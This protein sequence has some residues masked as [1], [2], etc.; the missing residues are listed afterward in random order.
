[1]RLKR[2]R[3]WAARPSG[4]VRRVV[5]QSTS[6]ELVGEFSILIYLHPIH[7]HFDGC[8]DLWH[9]MRLGR[10]ARKLRQI[11]NGSTA[12]LRRGRHRDQSIDH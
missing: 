3:A 6:A 2:V 1:M 9:L 8:Q 7:P 10:R 12:L 4:G 11:N 5:A